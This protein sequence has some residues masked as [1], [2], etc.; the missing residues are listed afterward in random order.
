VRRGDAIRAW[1]LESKRWYLSACHC[2]EV[3]EK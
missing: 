1:A 3:A 2:D